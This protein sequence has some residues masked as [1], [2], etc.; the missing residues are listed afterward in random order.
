MPFFNSAVRNP[1]AYCGVFGLKTTYGRYS[2]RIGDST[3]NGSAITVVGP[4]A[5][6]MTDL[7]IMDTLFGREDPAYPFSQSELKNKIKFGHHIF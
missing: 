1:A 4:I 3:S 7:I 2:S 6:S 5:G